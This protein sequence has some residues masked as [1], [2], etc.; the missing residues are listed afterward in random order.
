MAHTLTAA[1]DSRMINTFKRALVA[2][3]VEKVKAALESGVDPATPLYGGNSSLLHLI[4]GRYDQ[5]AE[6]QAVCKSVEEFENNTTAILDL[7]LNAGVKVAEYE[8]YANGYFDFLADRFYQS[9]NLHDGATVI[10]QAI[11]ET[12]E[13]G[14]MGYLPNLKSQMHAFLQNQKFA[15][16]ADLTYWMTYSLKAMETMHETVRAR[17]HNPRS[18]TECKLVEKFGEKIGY[19]KGSFP[20]QKL[21]HFEQTF[22]LKPGA[23]GNPVLSVEKSNASAQQNQSE[24]GQK[25]IV[26]DKVFIDMVTPLVQKMEKRDPKGILAEIERDFIGL[27][28]VK[29]SAR[30]MIVRQQFNTMRELNRQK[31]TQ[32]NHSTVFLGNPGLGKTTFARKKAEL[33]Y[34]LGLAGPNYVEVSPEKIVGGFIG[35]TEGKITALLQ[36]ADVIFIDEAYNLDGGRPDS[37]DFGKKVIDALVPALENNPNLVVFMAGYPEEMEKLLSSVNPGLRSRLTKYE[38]FEDMN[39]DQLGRVLDF[40]LDQEELLISDDARAYILDK[41]DASRVE[42]GERNFGNARLV[43]NIVRDLPEVMAERLCGEEVPQGQLIINIPSADAT[44]TVTMADVTALN[45]ASV[46][47]TKQDNASGAR[48]RR[49]ELPSNHRDWQPSIGFTAKM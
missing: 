42:L 18:E 8:T 19:W 41:L 27:D 26:G 17:L 11:Y 39:R 2:R 10:I 43:R 47:G 7:L 16:D 48:Q 23:D 24:T 33:L 13:R 21:Y 31:I 15:T 35:H 3:D 44:R 6:A 14:E 34:S 20:R 12:L 22:K 46:L 37:G 38:T 45:F 9:D 4:L 1:F 32:Q 49:K 36:M 25:K 30:K 40:M 28:Q 5:N 29:R